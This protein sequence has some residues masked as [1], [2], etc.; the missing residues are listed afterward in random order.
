MNIFATFRIAVL[1]LLRNKMRSFL[2][3]LGIIIG[4]GAVIAMVAIGE[5]A[6]AE[7]QSAF[8]KMGT[9]MLVVRSGSSQQGGVRGGA[10][11]Q[12]TITWDDVDAIAS[13]APGVAR[14]APSIRQSVQLLGD[15]QNWTTSAEGTV[16]DYFTIRAWTLKSGAFF[17]EADVSGKTKVIVL[18][19]TVADSLFGPGADPV[20]AVVRVNNVPFEVVGLLARK[21]QS[22]MGQDADDVALMPI[23]T[24]AAKIQ[25]GLKKYMQGTVYVGANSPAD[26][27]LAQ[28]SIDELL[29]RRHGIR[30]GQDSDVTVNNLAE[31]AS[32]RAE[33]TET[34][35]R[36]LAGIALVSLLVGGIGIM[37]IMLVSVTERTREI[38]LRMAIGAKPSDIRI[39][40]VIEA[41]TLSTIGGAFG[42]A[43]GVGAAEYLRSS[44]GW[45]T[46]VQPE[47]VAISLGFSAVVGV[48]FGLYPAHKASGLDPIT[49]LRFE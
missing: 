44:L 30:E 39:Q 31:A 10:G 11:S 17:S 38:G 48:G 43:L 21:G 13:E 41:V 32:A 19:A 24:F 27:K 7:V 45:A 2:T 5:G 18:G 29:R 8:D 34:M 14:V 23:S 47:I 33:G 37:N 25:G 3:V 40:F 9:N 26:T 46:V 22:A 12:P 20:G 36:L 4:V 1:A 28:S 15:G 16:P 6:K 42:V 35:T 49:A